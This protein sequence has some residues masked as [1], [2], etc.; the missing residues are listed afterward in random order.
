MKKEHP[1]VGLAL[2]GG[3]ALGIAHIG[4]LQ[5]LA[6]HSIA[7]DCIAGASAGSIIAA[8]HAFGIEEQKIVEKIQV[9][10]WHAMSKISFSKFG[11]ISNAKLGE[12]LRDILGDPRIE[13]AKIPLAI[14]ATDVVTGETIILRKGDLIQ[15]LLASC[16]IPGLFTPVTIDGH[17]LVDGG[18]SEN[19]PLSAIDVMGAELKIAV[20]VYKF[21]RST[22]K[23]W[24]DIVHNSLRI[25]SQSQYTDPGP[26]EIRIEPELAGYTGSDFGKYQELVSIGYRAAT[27]QVAEIQRR[28]QLRRTLAQKIVDLLR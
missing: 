11:F 8:C 22:P 17:M 28:L 19:L 24:F 26:D 16:A 13:D 2:S 3:S 23:N 18:V 7:V 4:V 25:L 1:S 15:A 12:L 14:M 6:D 27:V 21:S 9:L 5:S 20:N 10:S